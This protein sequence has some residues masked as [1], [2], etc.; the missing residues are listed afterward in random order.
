MHCPTAGYL[1]ARNER[2]SGKPPSLIFVPVCSVANHFLVV[3]G[4]QRYQTLTN[5]VYAQD[6]TRMLVIEYTHDRTHNDIAGQS[7][8]LNKSSATNTSCSGID[9]VLVCAEA[10]RE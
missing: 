3:S 1:Q 8:E 2:K 4:G 9:G 7:S 6:H 5:R 10:V